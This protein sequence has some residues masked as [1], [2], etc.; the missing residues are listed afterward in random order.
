MEKHSDMPQNIYIYIKII[1]K[2]FQMK[3]QCGTD[4]IDMKIVVADQ[5]K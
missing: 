2:K 3:T 5:T 1:N 4:K